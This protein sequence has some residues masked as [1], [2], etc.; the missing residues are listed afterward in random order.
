ML[1][2]RPY[3]SA[4][5]VRTESVFWYLKI[6]TGSKHPFFFNPKASTVKL[7]TVSYFASL[8]HSA[9]LKTHLKKKNCKN[10]DEFCMMTYVH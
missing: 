2:T 6:L 5:K 10:P 8:L 1:T 4:T 7:A 3:R 9:A